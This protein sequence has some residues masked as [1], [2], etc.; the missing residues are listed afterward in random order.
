MSDNRKNLRNFVFTLNNYTDAEVDTVCEIPHKYLIIGFEVGECGTPHIQ[1]Y[2]ELLKQTKFAT[3]KKMIPRAHIEP[4]NGTAQQAADY[5]KKDGDWVED[6]TISNPGRR[7]DLEE[8]RNTVLTSGMRDVIMKIGANLQGIRYAEKVLQYCE[9]A[10][11]GKAKVTWIFGA[12]G[13]GKSTHARALAGEGHWEHKEDHKWF[14]GYDGQSK[15]VFDEFRDTQ[16]SMKTLLGLI[17]PGP[18]RVEYKGGTRQFQAE[19]I[20]ITSILPP[21]EQYKHTTEP[22]KQLLRRIDVI[23]ES[24]NAYQL[25]PVMVPAVGGNTNTPTEEDVENWLKSLAYQ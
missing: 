12:S 11:T 4:R 18:M 3:I 7:S 10:R 2:C 14:D 15:V 13:T 6:G 8:V 23:Y 17:G 25:V 20:F 9:K 21:W 22:I 24:T 1:G 5:C 19:E 16:W